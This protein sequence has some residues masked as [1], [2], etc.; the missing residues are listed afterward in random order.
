MA[1]SQLTLALV[2]TLAAGLVATGMMAVLWAASE[3]NPEVPQA[4]ARQ[5]RPSPAAENAKTA[6][7]PPPATILNVSGRVLDPDGKPRPGSRLWLAFQGTDWTWSTRVPEVRAT[8]GPNGR[9]ALSV[10]DADPEV[11]RAL[12]MTSGWPD[13]F[14]GIHLIATA[15]GFGPGWTR[16]ADAKGDVELR[17]VPDDVPIEGRLLTLEGR[18]LAGL[19]RPYADGS[20]PAESGTGLRGSLRLLSCRDDRRRR[21]LPPGGDRPWAAGVARDRRT[22]H[23]ARFCASG[24]GLFAGRPTD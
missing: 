7:P 12:R 24:D 3:T 21:P 2:Y 4:I 6:S 16:L 13:G 8:A 23:P 11:Q 20:S 22:G 14:G 18:P 1:Q 10:S 9:F 5:A 15:E 19:D 17:L